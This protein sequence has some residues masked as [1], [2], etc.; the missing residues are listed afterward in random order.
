RRWLGSSGVAFGPRRV[1]SGIFGPLG[2]RSGCRASLAGALRARRIAT[3]AIGLLRTCAPSRRIAP[4]SCAPMRFW[5]G[6]GLGGEWSGAAL[7][8]SETAEEGK[9]ASAAMWPQFGAP[10]GFFLANGLFLIL[11]SALGYTRGDT[12]GPFMEWGWR[13]PFLAS[14]VMV[15]IGLY[16]R[17]KLEETPVFQNAVDQGK[18][19]KA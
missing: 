6:L 2:G 18:K 15:L 4:R 14:A 19:V 17:L 13:I 10:F 1:G 11:V 7:L 16:V 8:A 12:T 5:R 9:R 3:L